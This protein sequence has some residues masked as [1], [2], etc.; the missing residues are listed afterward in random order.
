MAVPVPGPGRLPS[1]S[2]GP[3]SRCVG[4]IGVAGKRRGER[5]GRIVGL[6]IELGDRRKRGSRR[7]VDQPSRFVDAVV[8]R[9][10]GSKRIA[11]PQQLAAGEPAV[12]FVV[13]SPVP[14]SWKNPSRWLNRRR[15]ESEI[16]GNRPGNQGLADESV[17]VAV[18]SSAEPPKIERRLL[19]GDRDDAA[20]AFLRTASTAA[21][22]D[23]DS[24]HVRQVGELPACAR[25]IDASTNTPTDGSMPGLLAPLPKPR[26]KKL[27]LATAW[28]WPTWS[29][30]TTVCRSL[31][32]ESVRARGFRRWSRWT[33]TGTSCSVC[34]S[35]VAVR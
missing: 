4:R 14:R 35:L 21:A 34:S 13:S 29:E 11:F 19:R 9:S 17:V 24:L 26:M 7:E 22:Q 3:S 27:V 20:E 30:G 18:I 15:P 32:R 5:I 10:A 25:T 8:M 16:V 12:A 28:R 23:L 33:A 6:A 2:R 31:G 1:A